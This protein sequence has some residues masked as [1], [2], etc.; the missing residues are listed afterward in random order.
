MHERLDKVEEYWDLYDQLSEGE[1]LNY[2]WENWGEL[3]LDVVREWDDEILE[4]SIQELKEMVANDKK[5]N[6]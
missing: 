4:E 2:I 3:M 6:S 1:R 5:V